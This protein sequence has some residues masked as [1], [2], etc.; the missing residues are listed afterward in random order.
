[1]RNA[2]YF[3]GRCFHEKFVYSFVHFPINNRLLR[4]GVPKIIIYA[5]FSFVRRPFRSPF[6]FRWEIFGYGNLISNFPF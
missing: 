2:H 1:M 6:Y 3:V 5:R 4:A